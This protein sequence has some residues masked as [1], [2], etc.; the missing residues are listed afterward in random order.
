MRLKKAAARMREL[1]GAESFCISHELWR[2]GGCAEQHDWR[3][4]GFRSFGELVNGKGATL[5]EALANFERAWSNEVHEE[6]FQDLDEKRRREEISSGERL[7][8]GRLA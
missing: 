5:T 1:V 4:T 6:A 7:S 8:D 2:H 3:V